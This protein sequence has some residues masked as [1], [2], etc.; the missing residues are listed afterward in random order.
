MNERSDTIVLYG[1]ALVDDFGTEQVVGGAPFNVARTLAA[2]G[3]APLMIT[4]IGADRDGA[5]VRAE[6]RRFGLAEDGLQVD[7]LEDTGRVLVERRGAS[8]QFSIL[9]DQAYDFI[10]SAPALNALAG[11][12]PVTLYFGTL[13][14]RNAVARAS[15]RNLLGAAPCSRFLD[16]NLRSQAD[17]RDWVAESLR[18]A[19]TVKVNEAELQ[20][21]FAW[22]AATRLSSQAVDSAPVH[23]ACRALMAQFSLTT[24]LITLG[25]R[26]ALC[27][28]ADGSELFCPAPP[29]ALVDSVGAGD[30]FAAVLLLGQELDWPLVQTLARANEL[31]S[32]ICA[33]H[34]A[35][36]RELGFY[37]PFRQRW[38][39]PERAP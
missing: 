11:V 36:P 38:Q 9:P 2:L 15:L 13:G 16:L 19:D 6:F 20:T 14:A 22:F 30:A 5:L 18:A 21:L 29:V 23:A 12:H 7:P 10:D 1:E 27:M 33:V 35:V 39:L 3:A 31:A 24:L 25:A 17:I 8:H 4:R 32:A 28:G 34:G 26:G 37:V